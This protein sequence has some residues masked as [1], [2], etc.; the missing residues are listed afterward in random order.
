MNPRALSSTGFRLLLVFLVSALAAPMWAQM[1]R[2]TIEG[3][4]TDGSGARVPGARIEITQTETSTT[5]SRT[6]NEQGAFQAQ[7]LPFGTYRV[8]VQSEGFKSVVRDPIYVRA[9]TLLRLD[10]VLEPGVVSESVIVTDVAPI[11][12]SSTTSTPTSLEADVIDNLPVISMGSKRNITQLLMNVPGLTS[13]DATDRESAT[14]RPAMNGAARGNTET[15]VEGGPTAQFGIARG[16]TEEVGPT[17]ETVGEFSV[18][19][20]SFNAEYGGFGSW[21]TTVSIKSGQNDVHGSVYN[22]HSNSALLARSFFQ[23][24]KTKGA[25][26]E[27]GFTLGGPVVIPKLYN[28]KNRTFFFG[29]LGLYY[30]RNGA[31]GDLRTVPTAAFKQGDFSELIS[32]GELVPIFD[33]QS[34]TPDGAGGY[35]RSP[36]AGNLIPSSRI[37]NA[38]NQIVGYMPDPDIPGALTNNFYSRSFAGTAWPYF[39]S[40]QTTAKVDHNLTDKQ[41]LSVTYLNQ[42]RHRQIQGQNTGWTN[43]IAWGSQQ[44]NPLDFTMFQIANSWAGRVNHDYMVTPTVLNHLNIS[45]DRY[46]NLGANGTNGGDWINRLG[47][48]GIPDDTTGSF[49]GITFAGGAVRPMNIGRSYDSA[50]YETR[51]SI[52]ESISWVRGDHSFKFG[53]N[54]VRAAVNSNSRGGASGT[55]SFS[56]AMTSQPNSPKYGSWGDPFASF[57]LGAVN[58]SD[59]LLGDMTGQRYRRYALFAQDEWRMTPK[60]TLSYGLRWDYNSP[61]F[62]V[63]NKYTS[64]EPGLANP[65]AGGRL[66]ALAFANTYGQDF[67]DAWRRGFAPRLGLAY[68]LDPKTVLRASAGIYYAASGN[69]RATSEGYTLTARFDSPNGFAPVYYWDTESFPQSF[70]R[71]PVEDPSFLNGQAV[72]FVPRNGTRLPQ[73]NSWTLT[74]QREVLPN[75]ALEVSYIGSQSTHLFLGSSTR[76]PSHSSLNVTPIEYL[77]LGSLLFQPIDSPAAVA[78]GF[79]EPFPGFANQKG[80]N[81][82][83]QAL[84]P[85]PQYTNVIS[86]AAQRPEGVANMHSLQI[87]ATKRFSHGLTFLTYFTWMKS[88][89]LGSPQYPLDRSGDLAVDAAA[90]PAV[91]G[92]TWTYQLPF[93][94][95]QKFSLSSPVA[96]TLISGWTLSGFLR[97]QAGNALTITGPNTLAAL[98][99]AQRANY[100]GGAPMGVTDP[101]TFDPSSDRYLN[102]GAFAAPGTF[103]LGNTA[104]VLDWARGF[105][106]KS[107]SF[108]L[109]KVT[110]LGE[111]LRLELGA[112]VSN[113]FNF[114]RWGA[115]DTS[116][117]SANFGRVTSTAQGRQVQISASL[118]F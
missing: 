83:A 96:R 103:E 85:F 97:Y 99:Y 28:G 46:I 48:T 104:P 31:S 77:S 42:V 76:A 26:N 52:D 1:A 40:Y 72:E 10:V 38:A 17:V 108:Q 69:Q 33:P 93:G 78:A 98:G 118:K 43:R 81:T 51:Y 58:T 29:A 101:G 113:P 27:G 109:S 54:H 82:V 106:S 67:Q 53:F 75:T 105:T 84:K 3:I 32:K 89:T 60:L 16:A 55:F 20:N 68:Q 57:L 65:N 92:T 115:P 117:T 30:T 18:V 90:S 44:E 80:A 70:R 94:E 107:E 22:H 86:G 102:R 95:G 4:V 50:L 9:E 111:N 116:V 100:V 114:H 24:E 21:F 62:E 11:I 45:V 110:N 15:F 25:Q 34:T 56:N 87:R 49:P 74:V 35:S 71:P 2:G 37:S 13:Y 112:D 19:T 91:F 88:M 59:A 6:T 14:W 39:N 41:R 23:R 36:F 47:L 61:M 63:N 7:S 73:I 79:T 66:G 12:D 64:F 5:T 8:V